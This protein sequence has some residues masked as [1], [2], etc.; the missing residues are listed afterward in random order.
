[1][2]EHHTKWHTPWLS[3]EFG[4]LAFRN[5][6]AVGLLNHWLDDG[7]WHGHKWDYRQDMLPYYL[8]LL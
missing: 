1:M 3:R 7:K 6:D 8:L 2:N 5:P 4:M